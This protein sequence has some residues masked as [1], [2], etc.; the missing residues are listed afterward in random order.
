MGGV[1]IAAHPRRKAL[2]RST[3]PLPGV[4]PT[5]EK[6]GVAGA[7]LAV[8]SDCTLSN[9]QLGTKLS[10]MGL[11]DLISHCR[12]SYE[13]RATKPSRPCYGSI[14]DDL[15]LNARDVADAAF[16][17]STRPAVVRQLV[18]RRRRAFVALG[19]LRR[20]IVE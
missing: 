20:A 7:R 12:T 14:L 18:G 5:L 2:D 13:L 8:L 6:L 19:V 15:G 10:Q 3:R 9:A 17:V 1:E 11:G 4:L 16:I